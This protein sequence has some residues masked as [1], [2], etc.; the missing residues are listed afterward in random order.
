MLYD[1][2]S[3]SALCQV[4]EQPG[5]PPAPHAL[6]ER[7]TTRLDVPLSIAAHGPDRMLALIAPA[8]GDE[9]TTWDGAMS[10]LAAPEWSHACSQE[11]T[12]MY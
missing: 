11:L 5:P 7:P 4:S 3:Y 9:P 8:R 6:S 2:S 1:P 12:A 10:S